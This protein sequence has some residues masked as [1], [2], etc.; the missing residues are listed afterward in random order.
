MHSAHSYCQYIKNV[1]GKTF[2]FLIVYSLL[3]VV[4]KPNG[5]HSKFVA[6][7]ISYCISNISTKIFTLQFATH[8]PKMYLGNRMS[9]TPLLLIMTPKIVANI[10]H[11]LKCIKCVLYTEHCT[12][13]IWQQT[14]RW[15]DDF[16]CHKIFNQIF[17]WS[18]PSSFSLGSKI[19]MRE[20]TKI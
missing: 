2:C 9:F 5:F 12:P 10:F 19:C 14:T 6:H 15:T 8:F 18:L 3:F 11:L 20:W 16:I 7:Y 1:A 13:W 4:Q 17:F